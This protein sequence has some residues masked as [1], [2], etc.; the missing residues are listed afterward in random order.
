MGRVA[1]VEGARATARRCASTC[2]RSTSR[3]PPALRASPP[4]TW[5]SASSLHRLEQLV[6][7]ME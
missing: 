3:C 7:R 1:D 5:M 4:L 2:L 6:G